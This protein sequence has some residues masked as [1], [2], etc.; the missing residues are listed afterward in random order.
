MPAP[1]WLK[2]AWRLCLVAQFTGN[3]PAEQTVASSIL[4]QGTC[5]GVG[6]VSGWGSMYFSSL[7][8]LCIFSSFLKHLHCRYCKIHVWPLQYCDHLWS[9]SILY[10]LFSC[11]LVIWSSFLACLWIRMPGLIY[12][13]QYSTLEDFIFLQR[14]WFSGRQMN[15]ARSPHVSGSCHDLG[16]CEAHVLHFLLV[17]TPRE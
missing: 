10:F 17:L 14:G 2:F 15:V 9:V 16:L 8:N 7:K 13:K 12:E 11:L 3:C 5:L 4:T 1:L 6:S